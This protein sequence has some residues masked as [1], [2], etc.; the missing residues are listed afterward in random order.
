MTDYLT[1]EQAA[2][3]LN[4]AHSTLYRWLREE[5]VPGHK[6]GRQWRFVRR[7][8]ESFMTDDDS[9]RLA[10]LKPLAH[11]LQSD[12]PEEPTMDTQLAQSPAKLAESLLWDAVDR[13]AQVV[14][15][16]PSPTGHSLRYRTKGGLDEVVELDRGAL[17]PL[18]E[19]WRKQS[20][21]VRNEDHRHLFLERQSDGETERVQV[22]YQG[23]DTLSGR[24]LTLRLLR[25]EHTSL[26][27]DDI[28]SGDDARRLHELCERSHGLVLIAGRGGSGKTTTAY[29]CLSELAQTGDRAVFTIEEMTGYFLPGVNQIEIDLGDESAYRDAF[30]AIFESDPDALFI[31]SPFSHQ[32]RALLWNAALRIAESGHLVFVQMEAESAQEAAEKFAATVDRPVDDYLVA[33]CW[34]QLDTDDDGNRFARYDWYPAEASE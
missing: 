10:A 14:H 28:A 5:K 25:E 18:D 29:V 22:R 7:E 3:L 27:I 1:F 30:S 6:V 11:Y 12:N 34:Q 21:A 33:S 31:S 20:T 4:I 17:E 13:G 15:L 32:R 24:R 26:S 8:L 19:H 2:D 9:D 23:L 16:Q